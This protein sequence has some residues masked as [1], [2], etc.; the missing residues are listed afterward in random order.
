MCPS[1]GTGTTVVAGIQ[2]WYSGLPCKPVQTLP[3]SLW[4]LKNNSNCVFL[5]FF[6]GLMLNK[7]VGV[8]Y[9]FGIQCILIQ[10]A[11]VHVAEC[12]GCTLYSNLAP[13]VKS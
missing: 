13:K 7:S 8:L 12:V 3:Y 10:G 1:S 2:H 9:D 6:G 11:G 4:H 5:G